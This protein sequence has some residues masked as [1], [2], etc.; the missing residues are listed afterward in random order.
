MEK[1]LRKF[2]FL[3]LPIIF[4]IFS[5]QPEENLLQQEN[6]KSNFKVE[7]I[8]LNQLKKNTKAFNK[9]NTIL[10]K[11]KTKKKNGIQ[12]R[13]VYMSE[14]DFYIETD[15]IVMITKENYHSYTFPIYRDIDTGKEENLVLSLS[16][17]GDY[18]E[19]ITKYDLTETEKALIKAGEIVAVDQ[20]MTMEVLRTTTNYY[21]GSGMCFSFEIIYEMCCNNIHNTLD[22]QQGAHCPCPNPPTKYTYEITVTECPQESGGGSDLTTPENTTAPPGGVSYSGSGNTTGTNT[23]TNTNNDENNNNNNEPVNELEDVLTIP[24]IKNKTVAL[25]CEELQK[26]TDPNQANLKPDIDWLKTKA[27]LSKEFGVEV[28]KRLNIDGETFNYPTTRIESNSQFAVPL[29]IGGSIIGGL[30]CHPP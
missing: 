10:N 11:S 23:G 9:L 30:H 7:N 6:Y 27:G 17:N 24:I 8:T 1:K 15:Q 28:E 26:L 2:K 16:S 3:I 4:V 5:C 14:Y 12:N 25:P 20:K 21:S 22:I 13:L 29:K 19:Y 18:K